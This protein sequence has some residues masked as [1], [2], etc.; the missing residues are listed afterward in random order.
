M[1]PD[2][3]QWI[4]WLTAYN[5]PLM[6]RITQVLV[7]AWPNLGIK[8]LRKLNAAQMRW[9]SACLAEATAGNRRQEF[10]EL[11]AIKRA[12]NALDPTYNDNAISASIGGGTAYMDTEQIMLNFYSK[13]HC[14]DEFEKLFLDYLQRKMNELPADSLI[15]VSD[16]MERSYR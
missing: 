15:K 14:D 13:N 5:A 8:G 16:N 3:A 9:L 10:D 2:N 11:M 6:K 4:Q 1:I 12:M 7:E